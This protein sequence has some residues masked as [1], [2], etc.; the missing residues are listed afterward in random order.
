M[1]EEQSATEDGDSES[2]GWVPGFDAGNIYYKLQ[3]DEEND[4]DY[5]DPLTCCI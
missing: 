1:A 5:M 2:S 4:L 3:K